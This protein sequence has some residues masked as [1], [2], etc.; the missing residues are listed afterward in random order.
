MVNSIIITK[1][2]E[3]IG[4]EA[5]RKL[6][7]GV[8]AKDQNFK[9]KDGKFDRKLFQSFLAKNGLD[10]EK[11]VNL[12]QND[13]VATMIIQTMSLSAPVNENEAI[14]REEFK[15]EKRFADVIKISE[16]NVGKVA[17]HDAEALNK[18]FEA[19]KKSYFAPEMRKVSYLRFS[20]IDFAKDLQVSDSEISA[21]YEKNKDKF[22]KP[23][24]RNL[25]HV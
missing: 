1:L 11:Y 7:L 17:A 20:K 24:S 9:D 16:K 4:V 22:Q 14:A 21:E 5:S 25:Y 3:D 12:I 15:Q 6:I 13:V 10:E 18:F 19:N 8:V 23:E 2:K